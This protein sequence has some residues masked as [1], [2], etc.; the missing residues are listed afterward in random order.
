MNKIDWPDIILVAEVDRVFPD[1]VM[2]HRRINEA[3]SDF[4]DCLERQIACGL[5]ADDFIIPQVGDER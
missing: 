2:Q 5:R 3:W 4:L 1:G